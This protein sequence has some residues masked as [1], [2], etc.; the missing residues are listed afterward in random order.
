MLFVAQDADV[1]AALEEVADA[2]VSFI[3]LPGVRAVERAHPAR[4]V[5]DAAVHNHVEVIRH[6][7][8]RRASPTPPPR[9]TAQQTDELPTILVVEVDR[10]ARYST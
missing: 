10:A 8:V 1:E 7:R 5:L 3:E 4:D 9:D 6:E 2:S